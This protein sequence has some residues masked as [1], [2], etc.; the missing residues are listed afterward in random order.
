V[1]IGPQFDP[2][3][4]LRTLHGFGVDYIVIGGIAGVAHGSS[5]A[6]FDLDVCYDRS[7]TNA[8]HLAQALKSLRARLRDIPENVPF[9]L[10]GRTLFAGDHLTFTTEV[11]DFDC[12]GT[13]AG[14]A[15]FSDLNS[16]AAVMEIADLS[17]KVASLDD[18]IRMKRATGGPKDRAAL[19]IL[20]ALRD[21]LA[22]RDSETG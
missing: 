22:E 9:R 18:L 13:P 20:G 6:T 3:K 7:R 11:G 1:A 21:L 4:I 10:D 15:G 19:E 8:D 12:I 14:T 2:L 17:V 16:N 5:L